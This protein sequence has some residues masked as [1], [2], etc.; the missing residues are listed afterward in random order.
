ME[1]W[2]SEVGRDN[3]NIRTQLSECKISAE[4]EAGESESPSQCVIGPLRPLSLSTFTSKFEPFDEGGMVLTM[5][6]FDALQTY[7]C[8][9][10]QIHVNRGGPP[11]MNSDHCN[12]CVNNV[13]TSASCD[14][15]FINHVFL[16]TS[17][18]RKIDKGGTYVA[19]QGKS[20][21]W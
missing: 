9:L 19:Q 13:K 14:S 16:P 11:W 5:E 2:T 18:V 8:P 1:K 12:R 15:L 4:E 21:L 7:Q 17:S 20:D 6:Q 3:L 10:L